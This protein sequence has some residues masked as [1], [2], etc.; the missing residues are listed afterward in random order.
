MPR[1]LETELMSDP[2]Q[3]A[4]YSEYDK[5]PLIELYVSQ[6]NINP[7]GKVL[8]IGCGS[9]DYFAKLTEVYPNVQ[10][11]GIDGS[12]EMLEK[13]K[14]KTPATV[15]LEHR[16][17]PDAT[18]TDTYDGVISSMMLHQLAD[19]MCLWNT[20]KQ[21]SRIGTKVLIMDMIRVEEAEERE[22]ILN[23]YAPV[24]MY[25]QFRA[26]FDNS[27]KAAFT[28]EEVQQ[29]LIDAKLSNL[30]VSTLQLD[31]SWHVLFITGTVWLQITE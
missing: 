7:T 23:Y 19:P 21:V 6:L 16:A 13:A 10:F 11:T 22:K 15:T 5:T 12:L 4:S 8:D 2:I 29:Q 1:I 18:I 30:E 3:V 31:A 20:I 26:D 24:D 14:T 9:G 28:V 25:P 27:M 17:I